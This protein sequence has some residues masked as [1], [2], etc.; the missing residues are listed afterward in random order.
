MIDVPGI[1]RREAKA[2]EHMFACL[3][4][5]LC[6][7][8][9][10]KL[11][12]HADSEDIVQDTLLKVWSSENTFDSESQLCFY[13]YRATHN[14]A[15][16][17]L[18]K[19]KNSKTL[20]NGLI[21]DLFDDEAYALAVREELYRMLYVAISQLPDQQRRVIELS[22]QGKSGKEIAALLNISLNTVKAHKQRA[23]ETLK[24]TAGNDAIRLLL[25]I[26]HI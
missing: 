15:V 22:I 24:K 23:I 18:R 8:V 14:N 21:P 19:N 10:T 25:L 16:S 5:P 3:Y 12:S 13:L 11:N 26:I 20:D 17:F 9:E 7:Y 4:A 2:W 1:N 6:V